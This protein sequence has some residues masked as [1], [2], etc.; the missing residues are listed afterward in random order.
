MFEKGR[1]FDLALQSVL[2][3]CLQCNRSLVVGVTGGSST[4]GKFS[5]PDKLKDKLERSLYIS[6]MSS[7]TQQL[8]VQASLL[9]PHAFKTLSAIQLTFSFGSLL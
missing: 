3:E 9:L 2:S 4:A 7:E 5:W 8:A 6:D 1:E